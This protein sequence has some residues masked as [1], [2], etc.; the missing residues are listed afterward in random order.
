MKFT[1]LLIDFFSVI[2]P[3]IFTF[4][5]RLKFY[6]QWTALFPAVI[7][8]AITFIVWDAYFTDLRI[9][10]F[11]ATYLTGVYIGNLPLE[12]V[13]FF[14]CI[15]YA[16]VFTYT[17]LIVMTKK[18]IS[19]RIQFAISVLLITISV[20]MVIIFY[21]HYYTCSAF[22]VLAALVFINQFILKSLWLSRFYTTYLLLLIPFFIVNGL[23]TGSGLQNAVVWYNHADIVNLR[24]LTIPIE[25]IFYGM[26]LILLNI[27]LYTIIT[28]IIYKKTN[29]GAKQDTYETAVSSKP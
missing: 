21:D 2:V 29:D 6:K 17:S 7:I 18:E 19:A 11:N 20:F 12:E 1:Y 25:D 8:T 28:K 14:I 5:P 13:L 15:P 9:W 26:D 16:C 22:A 23:L 24:I 4:H 27:T 3:L 10:G